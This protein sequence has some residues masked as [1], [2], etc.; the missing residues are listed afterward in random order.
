VSAKKLQLP[1]LPTF[2]KPTTPLI[3]SQGRVTSPILSRNYSGIADRWY[4]EI[5]PFLLPSWVKSMP[6]LNPS[7]I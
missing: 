7:Q 2:F 6:C 4:S 1:A 5:E 3:P